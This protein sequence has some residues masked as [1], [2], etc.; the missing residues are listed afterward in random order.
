MS[1]LFGQL[2]VQDVRDSSG[3]TPLHHAARLVN[4]VQSLCY[5]CLSMY[6]QIHLYV[7]RMC[8]VKDCCYKNTV[9]IRVLESSSLASPFSMSAKSFNVTFDPIT[10]IGGRAW[11][12][13]S[14]EWCYK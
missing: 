2:P 3:R 13:T 7:V 4:V 9:F 8:Y 6:I 11:F 14:H 10:E 5:H 1:R 12:K